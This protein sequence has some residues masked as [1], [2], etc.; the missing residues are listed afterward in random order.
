MLKNNEFLFWNH[1]IQK[2]DRIGEKVLFPFKTKKGEV[3]ILIGEVV[4]VTRNNNHIVK[5][6][7][8]FLRIK[9]IIFF[10]GEKDRFFNQVT[11]PPF[12][13][14]DILLRPI[15]EKILEGHV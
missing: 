12:S 9:T 4:R 6:G 3:E 11:R 15:F 7:D 13:R 8:N 14:P 2:V 10:I 1:D 5:V